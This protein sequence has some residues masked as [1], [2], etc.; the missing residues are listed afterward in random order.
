MATT[1]SLHHV[2]PS[3]DS[4]GMNALRVSVDVTGVDYVLLSFGI[5]L[6]V[7]SSVSW[8]MGRGGGV[9]FSMKYCLSSVGVRVC[10]VCVGGGGG[11]LYSSTMIHY[12][13]I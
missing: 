3:N 11:K 6:N 12:L 8:L 10:V 9:D 1:C 5:L 4:V 13:N 7:H 2:S